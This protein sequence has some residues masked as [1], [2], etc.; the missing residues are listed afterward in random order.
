MAGGNCRGVPAVVSGK[1]VKKL[2]MEICPPEITA[3]LGSLSVPEKVAVPD[4]VD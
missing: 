1:N 3:P 2:E 4:G